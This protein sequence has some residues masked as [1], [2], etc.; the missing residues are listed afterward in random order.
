MHFLDDLIVML[1]DVRVDT[2]KIAFFSV[3]RRIYLHCARALRLD[4]AKTNAK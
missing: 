2:L 3:Y 4:K 1:L